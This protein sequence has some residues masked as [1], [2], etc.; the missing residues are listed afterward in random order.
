MN[1]GPHRRCSREGACRSP[2]WHRPTSG[3]QLSLSQTEQAPDRAL[4]S[5]RLDGQEQLQTGP[6][7]APAAPGSRRRSRSGLGLEISIACRGKVADHAPA[8]RSNEPSARSARRDYS[9]RFRTYAVTSAASAGAAHTRASTKAGVGPRTIN[10]LLVAK[11]GT[12]RV[13]RS[14][15]S[16]AGQRGVLLW[17]ELECGPGAGSAVARCLPIADSRRA[18]STPALSLS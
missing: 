2:D 4:A 10:D 5:L 6:R 15:S 18:A 3:P 8:L 9:H 13:A 16:R 1:S 7:D 12:R 17:H 11:L 14:S